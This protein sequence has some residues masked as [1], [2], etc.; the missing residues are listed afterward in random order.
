MAIVSLA[1]TRMP[2][3]PFG[4]TLDFRHIGQTA[5]GVKADPGEPLGCMSAEFCQPVI[6]DSNTGLLQPGIGHTEQSDT[7][8]RVQDFGADP[9]TVLVL[10]PFDW[11]PSTRTRSLV[12]V[13]HMLAQ[14]FTAA[15]GGKHSGN[16]QRGKARPDE[17]KWGAERQT[18]GALSLD[19]S[20]GI[21]AILT[22]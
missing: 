21:V 9:V 14:F 13:L 3:N 8:A 18:A 17:N 1:I 2:F 6:V 16:R 7:Q 22:V 20:W 15:A 11:I 10:D 4:E 5:Q 12:T 19:D